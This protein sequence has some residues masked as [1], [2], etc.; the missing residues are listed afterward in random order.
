M[1][2]T[3][4]RLPLHSRVKE[5]LVRRLRINEWDASTPLPSER[6]LADSYEISVG[7][8][9]RVLAETAADGLIERHQGHGTF[10]RRADFQHSL[11][12]FFRL[13][14]DDVPGSRIV[15]REIEPAPAPVAAA[16]DLEPDSAVLHLHRLRLWQQKPFLLEDI[17]LPLPLFEPLATVETE[18]LGA[19]LYPEY[20][21]RVGVVIGSASEELSVSSATEDQARLLAGEQGEPVVRIDRLARTHAGD[22]VEYRE[23]YGLASSFRYRVEIN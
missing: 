11:F 18:Q 5:D 23:S 1:A 16:F 20:E 7:T 21:S 14:G 10:V 3:D 13:G 15:S 9:R 4:P 19:L 12:R 2:Q 8:M 17:W 6:A 22:V